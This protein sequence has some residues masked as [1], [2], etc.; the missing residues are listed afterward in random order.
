MFAVVHSLI[1]FAMNK[2]AVT[3]ASGFVG[4]NLVAELSRLNFD[5]LRIHY[6]KSLV[7][8]MS[9]KS[10]V[11]TNFSDINLLS[12]VLSGCTYLFHLGGVA[13]RF[14][15]GYSYREIAQLFYYGNYISS[16]NL[17]LAA[18]KAGVGR[19][20]FLSSIGV[21]NSDTFVLDDLTSP[22]PTSSYGK[23]KYYIEMFLE[24]YLS[25]SKM[26]WFCLRPPLVYGQGAPG[27]FLA[28]V[29]LVRLMPLLPFGSV[30]HKRSFLYVGNLVS[31]LIVSMKADLCN[32][33]Y[34]ISDQDDMTFA[35][36]INCLNLSLGRNPAFRNFPVSLL[37]VQTFFLMFGKQDLYRKMLLGPRIESSRFSDDTAWTPPF[38]ARASL[39]LPCTTSIVGK[40]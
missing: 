11:Y 18:E 26:E 39:S 37:L 16:V 10:E 27:N 25:S 8:E 24:K 28:L 4:R 21:Y 35:E 3:G 9:S 23:S 32:R 13:H 1:L 17:V 38:S 2:V 12:S 15:R 22:Q 14:F 36:M 31:A 30:I 5:V 20:I 34:L 7:C 6:S 29:K 40:R 33:S 19:F